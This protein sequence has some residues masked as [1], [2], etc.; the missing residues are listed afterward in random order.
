MAKVIV[1]PARS[2]VCR[3]HKARCA[4][5]VYGRV[6]ANGDD[7]YLP[8]KKVPCRRSCEDGTDIAPCGRCCDAGWCGP[9]AHSATHVS[10]L[11]MSQR[12]LIIVMSEATLSSTYDTIF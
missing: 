4:S 5:A 7:R 12:T 2:I 1:D 3:W 8:Y 6:N 9:T 10:G 11:P